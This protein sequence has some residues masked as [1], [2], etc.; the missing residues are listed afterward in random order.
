MRAP[1]LTAVTALILLSL[2]PGFAQAPAHPDHSGARD[3]ELISISNA[4][5]QG[6]NDSDVA[7]IST[8]GR[9]VA[10]SSVADNLVP[11]DTNFSSDVFVRDRQEDRIE[12]VSVGPFGVEGDG[13]SG[14]LDLLGR[15][16]ISGDGRFVAF[17]SEASNFVLG[18]VPGTADVFVHDRRTHRTELISRGFDGTPAG[19]SVAPAISEDG[20][21]VAF[22][23]FSDRLVRDGNPNFFDHVYVADREG[24][25]I[26][27]V[28]VA[29]D[30]TLAD[31]GAF[32]VAIS[33]HGRFVAFDSSA[34]NLVEGDGDQAPDVFVHD[35]RTGRTE[36]ISTRTPTDTFTGNSLL[37][38]ISPDG[39]FVG[40]EST[41]P[42]LVRRDAN[43]F[44]SDVFVFDRREGRLRLVSRNSDG[45]QGNND[46]AGALVSADGR[47]VVFS[48]RASNLVRRDVNESADVFRRDLETGETERIAAD[49]T[50]GP[51][52]PFGFDVVASEI[53]PDAAAAALLTRADLK[54][55]QDVGFFVADVYVFDPRWDRDDRRR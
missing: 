1:L 30:G 43:G 11:G 25:S 51:D 19:G 35:R 27:R 3:F 15:P 9:L 46:S 47:F 31:G 23:S 53:T 8:D 45:V 10:F 52:R 4:G 28:D 12:R 26:D 24:R 54:P 2:V 5:E 55:E 20:R 22:R 17:A 14:F 48:S 6:N 49:R 16:D 44:F 50:I 36:G 39:R 37:D 40:F 21:F 33:A 41:D 38:S 29:S 7:A 18:D 34:G 42:T 13:N 32:N